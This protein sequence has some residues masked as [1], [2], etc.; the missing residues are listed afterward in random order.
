MERENRVGG[1]DAALCSHGASAHD[2]KPMDS[3]SALREALQ[4]VMARDHARLQAR[5]RALG[6]APEKEALRKLAV[7]IHASARRR[8]ERMASVPTVS[9]DESLPIAARSE[10]IIDAIRVHQ[11][12][13]LA[14]ETG[15]GKT[16]QLPKLCLAAGRGLSGL[17]GCTQPRRL[18]A[19]AVA[20]RV[21]EEMG[22]TVGGYV[23]FQVRFDEQV[24]E[25]SLVK[26]MTD[27]I[28]LAETQSDRL[29]AAYDTLILDEAH[30]RSLNVDFLLGYLKRLLPHRP[31]LRLIV[32][33]ATLDTSRFAEFFGNAPVIAV[34]GRGYPVELRWRP[35]SGRGESDLPTQV[36]TALDEIT[37]DDPLGDVLVFLPGEREIRETHLALER[38]RYRHT[39]V[40]P[41]YARMPASEQDRVFHP[42]PER[43]VVLATNVA[44]TSLTVPRI[45][46]VIDGGLARVKRYSARSQIER[47]YI[48]PISQAAADQRKGRCGRVGPGLCVR[49]YSEDDFAQRPRFGDPEIRRTALAG[50]I[51]RMLALGLGDVERFPFIDAPEPRA[52]SEGWRRLN[53]IGAV[54]GQR[55]LTSTGKRLARLPIDVG[56]ARMVVEGEALG[57]ADDM[58]VLAAFLSVQDPRERPAEAR[59]AADSAHAEFADKRSDFIG[60]LRLWL[61]Y[62]QV[63][64]E[65][66]QSRLRAWCDR[67]F[68]SFM[69]MREWREIHRQLVLM[70][71]G[72]KRDQT[73]A[74]ESTQAD[75]VSDARRFEVVHRALLSGLPT[76]VARRDEKGGYIG[77]R[78][79]RW[80]LFPGSALVKAPPR[81]L[82]SAQVLDLSGRVY[83]MMNARVEPL[84]IEQQAAHLVKR[85]WSDP[86]WSRERGAVVAHE[87]VALLGL[88]LAER[89]LVRFDRHD[90]DQAHAIFLEQALATGEIDAS[91]E[92]IAANRRLLEQAELVEVQQRRSGLIVPSAKRAGFF[93]GKL[94]LEVSSTAALARWYRQA[95]ASQR[96]AMFWSMGDLLETT[97]AGEG[98]FPS[99]LS[100]AGQDLPLVYRHTPGSEDDGLTIRVPLALLNA[101]PGS[102]LEWLVPGLL[103]DKVTEM[104]RALPRQLRRNF[105]PA[106]EFARA[107]CEAEA[108]QD[109]PLAELL[110]QYLARVTGV[111]IAPEDF[112]GITLPAHLRIRI[113]LVD[114]DGAMVAAG[115]EL[116]VLRAQHAE[117]AREAFSARSATGI[118][119]DHVQ[120]F[121]FDE[122]PMSVPGAGGL[123]AYPALHDQGQSVSLSVFERADDAHD[124]HA[125]GVAR[126]LRLALAGECKRAARRLPLQQSGALRWTALGDLQQ[127]RM[128]IVEGALRTQ[129][130]GI[131]A[132]AIR[133]RA[134]FHRLRE[135]MAST[136][137][138]L[139][140]E[141]FHKVEL[142][143]AARSELAPWL[144]PPLLGYGRASYADLQ[145]QLDLLLAPGFTA[146]RAI[147]E[148]VHYPRYLKGMRLRAERLRQDAARDQRRLLEVLPYWRRLLAL[149][150]Q[151][152]DDAAWWTLR[153]LVEEWRVS[154]F[155]QDLGTAQ[156]V[157]VKRLQRALAAAE[158]ASSS[159]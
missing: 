87:Q 51:L 2:C 35:P 21:A 44:E 150:S 104:I 71:V 116:D 143:V 135:K 92:F 149:R 77:T 101:L 70:A 12:L 82:F 105:V 141:R 132:A 34:E 110:A 79:R 47:L 29:L 57:A 78:G 43:H 58:R 66:T 153:W 17:I 16:T 14:G 131:D 63:H 64:E 40:L 142:I 36:A 109:R 13:I 55:H 151:G 120:E 73:S 50:V 27:G 159:T 126:L 41:L 122:I 68:L 91:L 144:D 111:R 10:S 119:R 6:A 136:L 72:D 26:F 46:Y 25:H 38:R 39:R 20:R 94:P 5:L 147:G 31:D 148:L 54:D 93:L 53:E 42:G 127:L 102:R 155:A 23:G 33:S 45:R 28:L 74:S 139:A 22:T 158:N 137:F 99:S 113:E 100:L 112:A 52:W 62:R 83:G 67:H 138:A 129:L 145:E 152:R 125:K 133:S 103:Q 114:G 154:L 128:D 1:Y 30:E 24:A 49:L 146:D 3:P 117:A 89:R 118:Q 15:S 95:S 4:H 115:R 76:Q 81:W 18:A 84:W 85:S 156:P 48:E 97:R 134:A 60:V 86:H 88:N 7:Q 8:A 9:V 75:E 37:G 124:A 130:A 19:R 123:A 121:D 32:T 108:P 98:L 59:A 157:S 90:P 69:R 96:A 11:A 140:M 107:F 61:A 106:P 65:A 56:L 80:Q